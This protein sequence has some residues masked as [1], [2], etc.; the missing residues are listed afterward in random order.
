MPPNGLETSS[1]PDTFPKVKL[2]SDPSL[3]C[4]SM[5]SLDTRSATSSP[6]SG[7]GLSHSV[8]Q[9]GPTTDLFGQEV[10]HAN[11]LAKSG[12]GAE[13]PI[14]AICGLRSTD[15]SASL[16]LQLFMENRL[17]ARMA[18]FGPVNY[19]LT[20]KRW[21]MPLGFSICALRASARIISDNGFIGWPTPTCPVNTNGHQAGNNRYVTWVQ[22]TFGGKINP[23]R[24]LWQMSFP[25]AW[26]ECAARAMP[27]FRRSRR[28]LSAHTKDGSKRA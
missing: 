7:D 5:T 27:S 10:A 13:L 22:R 18:A 14:P 6:G 2:T 8:S 20:W 28:N 23:A 25:H 12:N 16:A 17:Q 26:D 19:A 4:A 21:D 15:L 3:T 1:L 24:V 9:A 11:H